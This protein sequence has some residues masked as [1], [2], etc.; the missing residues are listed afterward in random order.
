MIDNSKIQNVTHTQVTQKFVQPARQVTH[1]MKLC[2]A[3][4]E[5]TV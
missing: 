2:H 3:L 5:H 4:I 1:G